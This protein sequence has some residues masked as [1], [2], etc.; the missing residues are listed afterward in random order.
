VEKGELTAICKGDLYLIRKS[1]RKILRKRHYDLKAYGVR[2]PSG[3][4]YILIKD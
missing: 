2:N 4:C 1:D 3:G